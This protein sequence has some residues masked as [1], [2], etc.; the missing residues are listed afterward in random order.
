M[1]S[2]RGGQKKPEKD[3]LTARRAIDNA[4][5]T[6]GADWRAQDPRSASSLQRGDGK[7]KS[8]GKHGEAGELCEELR[9]PMPVPVRSGWRNDREK[10]CRLAA[11]IKKRKR[12]KGDDEYHSTGT[13]ADNRK[14]RN[15]Q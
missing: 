9:P 12:K 14:D 2:T 1:E 11:P 4:L 5:N 6:R 8:W 15:R 10:K 7:T 3:R 13:R